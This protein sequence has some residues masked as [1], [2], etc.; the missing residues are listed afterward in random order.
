M[1]DH[2]LLDDMASI[3]AFE[4]TMPL[5]E[6]FPATSAFD[7]IRDS[8]QRF[9][10]DPALTFLPTGAKDEPVQTMSYR[11]LAANVTATANLLQE[12]GINH[13]D[14]VS[15]I[16]PIL[17]QSH[18]VIL[19]SQTQAIANPINPLLEPG[20]IAD[21]MRGAGA[22]AVVCLAPSRHTDIW[23][24][25]VQAV[26][27]VPEIHTILAVSL[28]G[29]TGEV[30]DFTLPDRDLR[31]VDFNQA[32]L[33]QPSDA[34]RSPRQ[35]TGHE[36]AACFHTGGTT[37]HP[38]I[39]RL[40]HGNMAYIGQLMRV[41]TAHMGRQTVI[42]GL[43]LFHIFGV[44]IQ[45]VAAFAIGY[46]VVLLTPSG[47]RNT[48]ALRNLWHHVERFR[49]N[50]FATVPTVLTALSQIPVGSHDISSLTR[51]NSGAAPLSP[52]F[53]EAFERRFHLIVTNGYGMTETTSLITRPPDEQPDGSVGLRLPYSEVRIAEMEDGHIIRD[54][55]QGEPGSIL[56]R[57]PQVF[58]GYVKEQDNRNAFP[59]GDWF[60][61]GDLGY[62][63]EEGFLYL[64]GRSRDLI[65]RG[66]HNIDPAL[67]EEALNAHPGVAS[68]VA[69]G[70]PDAYAGELPMAFVVPS[71][72]RQTSEKA[73]LAWCRERINERAAIPKRIVFV[74]EMP[75]T[76]VGKVFRP[77][78]RERIT[79]MVI[80]EYLQ[81]AG[82]EATVESVRYDK[83]RGMEASVVSRGERQDEAIRDLLAPLPVAVSVNLS[84]P[85]GS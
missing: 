39:A 65:I 38:K 29:L 52:S 85:P 81:E 12:S 66:G 23:E 11:E 25:T 56:V 27:Q 54:C 69:V 36:I 53:E 37:G 78:L 34:L 82:L 14:A 61:T 32:V 74:G 31:V 41:L 77:A 33:R 4:E 26:E 55:P 21:I 20:Q 48:E 70:Q 30:P 64:T 72:G 10:D 83:T 1:A 16:L 79:G 57:G 50:S 67:I 44:I 62:L 63:D 13:T 80:A 24:K 58:A 42:C 18:P 60:N 15:I 40:T 17:P 68:A 76:A 71:A 43:P 28:P 22:R 3:R 19:G 84:Q 8:G 9:G 49:V 6:R 51:I 75:V 59:E 46:H 7:I 2:P 5:S 35:F 73:L 47:F 45:G